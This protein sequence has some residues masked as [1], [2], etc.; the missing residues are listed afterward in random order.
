MHGPIEPAILYFGTPVVVISTLNENGTTNI[1]PMSS[2]WWIGWSAMLGLDAS[3][4]TTEN[5]RCTGECVLN[6][7]GEDNAAAVDALALLSGSEPLPPH[8][9]FLGYRSCADK[10]AAAGLAPAP[11]QQVR[12]D[13]I[14]EFPVR[15]EA[16]VR[17]I[18]AFAQQDPRL[19]IPAC[20]VEVNILRVEVDNDLRDAH[21]PNRIDPQR[22]RPL[23]M[24]FRR[25]FGITPLD[26][27][28]RLGAAPEEIY[29]PR[30]VRAG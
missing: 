14:R 8:K 13:G 3:S 27:N 10:F 26:Q 15:L 5:L 4:K 19:A 2:A 12:P 25:F 23:I 24:S 28:S 1:A 6:L 11:S 9:Q 21:H 30:R 29:A 22:W 18:Q 20:A 17:N 16:R 7:A